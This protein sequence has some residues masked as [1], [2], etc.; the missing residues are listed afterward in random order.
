R[1]EVGAQGVAIAERAY[2]QALAYARERRQGRALDAAPTAAADV[3]LRHP[4]VRRMLATMKALTEAGRAMAYLAAAAM[5]RAQAAPDAAER[6]AAERRFAL[7]T[8]L[9]KAWCTDAGSQVADLGIQVHGGVGFIEETGAA[10]HYRDARILRIYE[11]TNGIQAIDLL[12]RKLLRD[13]GAE[14]KALQAEIA[15]TVAALTKCDLPGLAA[16]GLPTAAALEAAL[17][18]QGAAT[19]WLLAHGPGDPAAAAAGATPYCQLFGTLLGG[20]LL[21]RSALA[22]AARLA[23]EEAPDRPFLEGKI[24]TAHFFAAN[25]L[26][27]CQA[28][29]ETVTQGAPSCLALDDATF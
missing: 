6:A 19:D 28:L 20:W 10:Q 27:H 16:A 11:G 23:E 14:V 18:A 4:D 26:P 5:D 3:I 15:E 2:Q 12:S 29:A 8:P 9:V 1:L 7:L 22:A 24:K 25:L 17:D 13:G 21:A